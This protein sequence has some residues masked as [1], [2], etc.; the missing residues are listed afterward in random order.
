MSA[1]LDLEDVAAGHPVAQAELAALYKC[2][3]AL[4]EL[5]ACIGP[6]PPGEYNRRW[7]LAHQAARDALAK[8]TSPAPAERS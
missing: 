1:Q 8:S 5:V 6:M 4:F 2:R 3:D 7:P